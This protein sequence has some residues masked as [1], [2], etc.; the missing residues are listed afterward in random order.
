MEGGPR[1]V[2]L[3]LHSEYSLSEG[4][5]RL[6]ALPDLC[7]ANQMPA[8]AV[9]DNNNLFAALE[10]STVCAESG[11]QPIHG[12]QFDIA[13]E[14]GQP[15]PTIAAI[16]LLAQ[17][18]SG[19]LSLLRLNSL[20]YVHSE[21]SSAGLEIARLREHSEGLI[22]LT[23]AADGPLG[24]LLLEGHAARAE[25]MLAELASIFPD[26]LYIELQR[27]RS[28]GSDCTVRES[29]VEPDLIDLAY[30]SGLPLVA[31]NDVHFP[32][33]PMFE[34]HDALIC[35][36]QGASVDQTSGRRKLTEEH[37][38]KSQNE[39]V[40][41]FSDLPEAV[42]N[43]VEI[44]RRCSWRAQRREPILPKF[45]DNEA[46]ELRAQAEEGLR[47][48][49]A[50]IPLSAKESEY[51]ERLQYELGIIEGVGY[52]G[53]FLIVADFIKWAKANGIPV[54]AGRGSGA[55]SL[56]AFALTITDLDPLR[57]DLL[58]ERFL[59]PERVSMPDFD[60]DFC[61]D[62]RDEVIRYVQNK[63]GEDKVAHIATFGALLSRAAVRDVGRVLRI[64]YPKVDQL[65]KLIPRDGAR[66]LS[67][68][69]AMAIESRLVDAC[70]AD[71]VV[72]RM[73]DFAKSIE[74]LLR[75]VST[76]AAGVVIGDRPLDQLVPLYRDSDA[77]MPAT[78]F[79]MKWA[80][81]A[82]LVKFDFLGLKT[83]TVIS[84][85]VAL[86]AE[87]GIEV[88]IN[89]IPLD[90]EKVF[91]MCA[92]A[93]TVAIFQLESAG[94]M[95]TL[96]DLVPTCI[97][98]IVALVAL[99]RPGPMD[100]I[101]KY[102]AVKNGRAERQKQHE[103]IDRIVAETHGIMVYQEQVMQI[104]QS[105]AGYS[106][107]QADLLRRAIG[108]KVKK[109]MDAEQ[110][111]FLAG[112]KENGVDHN[113][114]KGVW[115]LMA[116]FAEYGFPKAHA[117]AYA[118]VSYQTAWLKANYPV[119]FMTSAM[120]CDSGDIGK[121]NV[122]SRE[123]K[124]LGIRLH[125]PCVNHSA[126]RFSVREGEI[127]YGLGA[128]RSVGAVAMQRIVDAR[129]DGPFSDVFD[130]ASRV[131][132]KQ[133]GKR[134]VETLAQAGAFDMFDS[135]RARILNAT[136]I[137]MSHSAGT[138]AER[139]SGQ[140]SLFGEIESDLPPPQIPD[141]DDWND[142]EKA[143]NEQAALGIYLSGH[144]LDEF[145]RLLKRRK[146]IPIDQL[147]NQVTGETKSFKIAAA[148]GSIQTRLSKKGN[149]FA[150]VEFSDATG[151]C[152]ATVFSEAL[153]TH[154]DRLVQGACVLARVSANLDLDQLK[155]RVNELEFLTDLVSGPVKGL[156]IHF[157]SPSAPQLV[158]SVLARDTNGEKSLGQIRFCPHA[159]G[160][161]S[162]LEIA[163]PGD[164]P[165]NAGIR[166]A[167]ASL[168]G[169]TTVEDF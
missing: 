29:R 92:A 89:N 126:A 113:T 84:N 46:V 167:I 88:D 45:A 140:M 125:P 38:F 151:S 3:R 147:G 65:A 12:C 102:C 148:V 44:A 75:N 26:R 18:E 103:S 6:A 122:Y 27:H 150:F 165:V 131:D 93:E 98:D 1:F 95:E 77:A 37:Y 23:G 106:L 101:P 133:I 55:G 116:R 4:A 82:G 97:E 31:T 142:A 34:A 154:R 83:L 155:I 56:V 85:A 138:H 40:E 42:A 146:I 28:E 156:R 81:Q 127:R 161:D 152:E 120:N 14:C 74:G 36:A 128:L 119:E 107:G 157:K 15:G 141:C 143:E 11:V 66:N 118:I 162:D 79:S 144:P 76:H 130:F 132:L 51:W 8:V 137:L 164:H 21:N 10:F 53:Y 110:P 139:N 69:E 105:M 72:A 2:H 25:R 54:G 114:A 124:R 134:A 91:R 80:E 22:C 67:I 136:D 59:N 47:Q 108:K 62:R 5:V 123:L 100:N 90:D 163:I 159:P 158:R 41:L 71:P 58:F 169:V 52:A 86:L 9:T 87:R 57:F 61:M 96:R 149:R 43:T 35:I 30:R 32:D 109:D 168:D 13:F 99:Y 160:L 68:D 17:D 50:V 115:D 121:L 78:Q 33:K 166:K 94:M 153:E 145:R 49:L 70:H 104:A 24:A 135:N 117:A 129:K 60:I 7:A 112:C 16:V 20:L 63:Y 111:K 73:F 64:P 48:R 39:M 19:Y